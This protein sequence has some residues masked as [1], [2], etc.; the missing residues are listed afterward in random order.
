MES[1]KDLY[2]IGMGPSSSHTIGPHKAA[3]MFVGRTASAASYR[4]TLYGSLAATGKGHM[5]DLAIERAVA[6]KS[7]EILWRA[8]IV[9]EYHTNGMLFEALDADGV[10]ADSWTVYSIG[11]G[12]LSEGSGKLLLQEAR[13][14]YG[15]N[16]MSEILDFIEKEGLSFWEY[17]QYHEGN[18][19]W[20][21]LA[22]VWNVMRKS[23]EDGLAA[24]GRLP[25]PQIS[26]PWE[27][28]S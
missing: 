25:G 19:I 16:K 1:I 28:E 12:Y 13:D 24:E 20:D 10:V 9:P 22:N 18:D 26:H 27:E 17:V 5:T 2:K 8:D 4:V 15:R 6:P 14:V 7:V 11:G 21:F 3:V 23:I